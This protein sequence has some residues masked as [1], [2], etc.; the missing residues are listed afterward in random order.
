MGNERV[1][2]LIGQRS[3]AT[4][5]YRPQANGMTER[6]VQTM[7]H[8]VRLY[9]S[10]PQQRDWDDY[11]ERLVFAL[12]T[13]HD[14]V[15]QETPFYLLHGWDP[16]STIETNLP[17]EPGEKGH[18]QARKWRVQVQAKYRQAREDANRLLKKARE[19]R[20]AAANENARG[21][22]EA[23]VP[24]ARVWL[25]VDQVKPGFARK[26][27]HLW[28]G[29]FRVL[30]RLEPHLVRLEMDSTDYR[31]HPVVHVSRLKLWRV[32]EAR[33]AVQLQ[34]QANQ[35]FDLGLLPEDSFDPRNE[36]DEY[37]IT[38]VLDHREE[39]VAPQ[40]RKLRDYLVRWLGYDEPDWVAEEDVH[41]PALLEE[42]EERL[43]RARGRLAVMQT[44]EM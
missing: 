41:A 27:E 29:P 12:N 3:R 30:E 36:D 9:V 28:H 23:I 22:D 20:M 13:A 31:M 11:A 7:M 19:V 18:V 43:Q 17:L 16:Y 2:R 15:R 39:R 25:Y 14:R 6:M 44:E 38:E 37:E 42:Y 34:V 10:H 5:A 26:L 8:A 1:N 32:F 40:G 21:G 33:P 35:R 4:L 24:G